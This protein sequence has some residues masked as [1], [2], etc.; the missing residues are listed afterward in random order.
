M[1]GRIIYSLVD[2]Q[3]RDSTLEKEYVGETIFNVFYSDIDVI[4]SNDC[5]RC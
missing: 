5:G 3:F 2:E 4:M 1:I